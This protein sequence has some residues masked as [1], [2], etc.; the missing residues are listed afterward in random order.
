VGRRRPEIRD[1]A[2]EII[3]RVGEANAQTGGGYVVRLSHS[4]TPQER[5]QLLAA[6]LQGRPITIMPHRC[7]TVEE[8]LEQYASRGAGAG[9]GR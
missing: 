8:W 6:R 4:P 2:A 5:L 7:R 3:R 9:A 1:V